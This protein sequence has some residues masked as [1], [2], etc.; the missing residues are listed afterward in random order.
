MSEDNGSSDR[1][2]LDFEPKTFWITLL[3][4]LCCSGTWW[5][6]TTVKSWWVI[7][8]AIVLVCLSFVVALIKDIRAL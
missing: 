3:A 2:P 1:D 6:A 8:P 7:V 4:W 5:L